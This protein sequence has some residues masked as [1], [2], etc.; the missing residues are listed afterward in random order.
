MIIVYATTN[1]GEG[2]VKEIGRYEEV[3]D[4]EIIV[5][6]FANDVVLTFDYEGERNL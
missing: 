5:G 2:R 1:H 3:E 6:M 4:I